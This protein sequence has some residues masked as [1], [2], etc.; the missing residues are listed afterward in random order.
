MRSS[1]MAL[2]YSPSA[3]V[4]AFLASI[5]PAPVAS[6]RRLTSAAVKAGMS[7]P[8]GCSGTWSGW[9]GSAVAGALGAGARVAGGGHALGGRDLVRGDGR[10]LGGRLGQRGGLAT[11]LLAGEQLAL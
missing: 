9:R 2:S 1:S 8:S 4:R 6:R 3:S 7:L 11:V 5:M 10:R